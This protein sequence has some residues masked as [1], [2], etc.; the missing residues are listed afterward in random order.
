MPSSTARTARLRSAASAAAGNDRLSSTAMSEAYDTIT[1]FAY[2]SDTK[3]FISKL[4]LWSDLVESAHARGRRPQTGPQDLGAA[5]PSGSSPDRT[6]RPS[7]GR[8]RRAGEDPG[9]GVWL[10][11]QV[12]RGRAGGPQGPPR[13]RTAAKP[14]RRPAAAPLYPSCRQ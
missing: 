11:G 10:A 12:P 8:R 6:G 9:G 14:I 7:R 4:S 2:R 13:P 3:P 1:P 5:A